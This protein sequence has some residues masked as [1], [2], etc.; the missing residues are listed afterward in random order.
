MAEQHT[1]LIV[2]DEEEIRENLSDF[3][4]F[5][6]F[7]VLQAGNGLQALEILESNKPDTIVSDLMMPQMGGMQLLQELSRRESD[8]PVVIMTAFGTMEYA[9]DAM[10]NGAADFLTKPIDLPYMLKVVDKILQRSAMQQ[11]IKEQQMQLEDDLRHAAAIQRCLL[12]GPIENSHLSIH[13]RYEPLI[14]I[15]GDY[16]TIHQY[17]PQEVAI[18]LYDVSGHGVSAALTAN[19]VHNQ[20]Q[21]RLAERRPPSNVINLLNRFITSNIEKTSMFVTMAI[22]SLD[23]EEG[24]MTVTNAGHPDLY[25]WRNQSE[26]LEAISSHTPPVGMMAKIL[27]DNNESTIDV[28]SGDRLVLYTDGFLEARNAEGVMLG[29]DG[30]SNMIR[31]H[32]RCRSTDFLQKMYDDLAAYHAGEPDDR[33]NFNDY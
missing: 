9:I 26:S 16:L 22:V 8:I 17:S 25:L 21:Q 13:Y 20:L 32:C 19:L 31:R 14:A 3:A 23:L 7:N 18:A 10:K 15:G 2:D 1:L 4:E 30:L 12:S 6:G 28:S 24:S 27:G 29:K 5:K 11:K 33:F